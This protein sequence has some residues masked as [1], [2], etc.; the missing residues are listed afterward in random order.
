MTA[1]DPLVWH[2]DMWLAREHDAREKGQSIMA[3]IIVTSD[4]HLGITENDLLNQLGTT[5]AAQRPDLTVLAGDLGEP[6]ENFTE[7]LR[8][9]AG[10]P[11]TVAVLPGNHDVWARDGAQSQE[12]L[13]QTLPSETQSAGMLW[14]EDAV[15]RA[16]DLAV[17]GSMAWYDYS[18]A[19][20]SLPANMRDFA[21]MKR[22][23]NNDSRYVNWPWTDPEV[24]N[25]L[26]AALEQRLSALEADPTIHTVVV[27]THVPLVE[28]QMRR[29]PDD[30]TWGISNAYFGNLTLGERVLR[31]SKVRAVISGHTH[32]GMAGQVDRAGMAPVAV[33]VV[34]SDYGVPR[35]LVYDSATNS[36]A[37]L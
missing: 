22:M 5:I 35:A 31:F 21:L 13:E 27:V 17:A 3:K 12:L 11:G 24:A 8:I 2:A 25:R 36:I 15:W 16:D 28:V 9:F 32:I 23:L 34:P 7:C 14:L 33:A 37:L 20:P 4:L 6:L 19:D 26:G 30:V 29:R 10:L 18:A 1:P